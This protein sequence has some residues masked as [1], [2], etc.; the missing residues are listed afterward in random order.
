MKID[1]KML[2][3]A[4]VVGSVALVGCS[5]KEAET[6]AEDA[7]ASM[8]EAGEATGDAM[9]DAASSTAGAMGEAAGN[10]VQAG[11]EAAAG[12]KEAGDQMVDDAK[13]G[14]EAGKQ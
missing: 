1:L 8:Q 12:V 6:V 11:E 7:S 10:V 5:K 9:S 14:Y 13:A 3:L 2:S 4:V